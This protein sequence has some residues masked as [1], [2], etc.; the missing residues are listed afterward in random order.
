LISSVTILVLKREFIF[1]VG[2]KNTSISCLWK[3]CP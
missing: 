3:H 1:T 2:A